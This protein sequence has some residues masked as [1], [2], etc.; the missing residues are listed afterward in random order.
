MAIDIHA[1]EQAGVSGDGKRTDAVP[2]F[3]NPEVSG[4]VRAPACFRTGLAGSGK[5]YYVLEQ[6]KANPNW[7]ILSS[8]T[9]ISAINIGAVTLNSLLGY[10]DTESLSGIQ[11]AGKLLNK[12][13][14]IKS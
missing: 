6:I 12:L 2:P 10:F 11:K 5:S 14:E 4:K 7:G 3:A 13:R 8:T 9:G 1:R